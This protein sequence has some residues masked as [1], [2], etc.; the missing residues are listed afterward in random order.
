MDATLV[1]GSLA[2][3]FC[4][5]IWLRL[6]LALRRRDP[7]AEH[8]QAARAFAFA[9]LFAAA[10]SSVNAVVGGTAALGTVAPGLALAAAWANVVFGV[11]FVGAFVAHFLHLVSGHPRAVRRVLVAYAI[12]LSLLAGLILALGP[13]GGTTNGWT[14]RFQ[15]SRAPEWTNGLIALA[16]LLPALFGAVTYLGLLRTARSP[17]ARWR[18]GLVAGGLT[19]W[20]LVAAVPRVTLAPP[21]FLAGGRVVGL[22]ASLGVMAAYWPPAFA[23]RRWGIASLDAEIGRDVRSSSALAAE[24]EALANRVR[25]L[26]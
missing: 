4:A 8:R 6:G 13:T 23:Q 26:I 10:F 9:W 11:S 7:P 15:F 20:I 25:E 16:V 14:T 17:T 3:A 18:I 19:L 12:Q 22:L 1:V 2:S 24:R 5:L 21:E